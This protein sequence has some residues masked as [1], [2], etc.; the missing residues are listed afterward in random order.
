ML[1]S[2]LQE[3]YSLKKTV[4]REWS[5]F[6]MTYIMY[7]DHSK[8]G[9]SGCSKW[10]G[11][12]GVVASP[13]LYWRTCVSQ[14]CAVAVAR[15][16]DFLC[17]GN[18]KCFLLYKFFVLITILQQLSIR[19]LALCRDPKKPIQCNEQK[20]YEHLA[21]FVHGWTIPAQWRICWPSEVNIL[22]AC[23]FLDFEINKPNHQ[24]HFWA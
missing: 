10:V 16:V 17:L 20:R 2:K 21:G 18:V 5:N 6:I 19:K 11:A 12:R 1:H 4:L 13:L 9:C 8:N 24:Q 15:S 23:L 3:D 7:E 14:C 22:C